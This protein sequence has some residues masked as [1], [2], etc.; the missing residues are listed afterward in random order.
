MT[1]QEIEYYN[2]QAIYSDLFHAKAKSKSKRWRQQRILSI[3]MM[4]SCFTDVSW[5]L[6]WPFKWMSSAW[7]HEQAWSESVHYMVVG[8]S[9]LNL[10]IKIFLLFALFM[11]SMIDSVGT[12]WFGCCK[13][14]DDQIDELEVEMYHQRPPPQMGYDFYGIP[15]QQQLINHGYRDIPV[16]SKM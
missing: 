12:V 7:R 6:Y 13:A 16:P 2:H 4:F 3:I 15:T 8:L 10:A 11:P 14:E 5:L 1:D 9:A